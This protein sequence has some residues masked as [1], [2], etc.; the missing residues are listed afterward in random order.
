MIPIDANRS[1][2]A[3]LR[4]RTTPTGRRGIVDH[5][6]EGLA[7]IRFHL[8]GRDL[9]NVGDVGDSEQRRLGAT[10]NNAVRTAAGGIDDW[11]VGT[12]VQQMAADHSSNHGKG[13]SER[14][15]SESDD[16]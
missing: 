6:G 10:A 2:E 12:R 7:R 1:R 9:G 5:G 14:N 13:E 8:V 11:R 4:A 16:C 3:H 15:W